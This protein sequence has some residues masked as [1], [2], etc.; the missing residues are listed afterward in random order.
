M[1]EVTSTKVSFIVKY[2]RIL[3]TLL[4]GSNSLSK[5]CASLRAL[6][7]FYFL[8]LNFAFFDSL[9][10]YFVSCTCYL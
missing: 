10:L 3:S 9:F 7:F 2:I 4:Q 1:L 8:S 6:F 5:Y